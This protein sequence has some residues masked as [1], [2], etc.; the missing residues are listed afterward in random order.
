MQTFLGCCIYPLLNL[1]LLCSCRELKNPVA[2]PGRCHISSRLSLQSRTKFIVNLTDW[3]PE[4]CQYHLVIYLFSIVSQ[5]LEM[6]QRDKRWAIYTLSHET[7]LNTIIILRGDSGRFWGADWDCAQPTISTKQVTNMWGTSW[8]YFPK[9]VCSDALDY[10]K[11]LN[12]EKHLKV[13]L[14]RWDSW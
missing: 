5:K 11:Y 7:M 14:N 13:T 1:G 6:R 8:F 10:L 4:A 3:L 2:Q 9:F 12:T